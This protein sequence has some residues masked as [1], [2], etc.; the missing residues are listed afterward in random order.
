MVWPW[1]APAVEQIMR[2]YPF[3]IIHANFIFPSGYIGREIKR[4]YGVPL[5][6]HERSLP[7]LMAAC[8]HRVR[9]K[10]YARVVQDADAVIT[11]NSKMANM[12]GAIAGSDGDMNIAHAADNMAHPYD[13]NLPTRGSPEVNV[14]HAA[15]ADAALRHDAQELPRQYL[16]KKIV[17]SVGSLIER[18]GHEY[19]IRAIE[20][21]RQEVPNVHC[22]IIGSGVRMKHLRRLI[23]ELGL[24]DTVELWGQL[25]H[26]EVLATMRWCDVFV[27]PSWEEAGGT[28]YGEAMAFAKPIIACANGGIGEVAQ[29][30]LHG[31]FVRPRDVR[32]LAGALAGILRDEALALRLGAAAQALAKEKLTYDTVA[33]RIIEIYRRVFD[34]YRAH[35]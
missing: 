8:D 19:L 4:K 12:I 31:L 30:G 15:G 24:E 5:I 21:V 25:P 29:D 10:V 16:T 11:I 17:L 9:R 13:S 3:Q 7:R 1:C 20:V 23:N 33:A 14:V 35:G 32:S 27:L 28:V 34:N 26:T 22:I 6:V 18:K 2:R